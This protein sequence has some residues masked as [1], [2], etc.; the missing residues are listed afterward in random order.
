[1][2]RNSFLLFYIIIMGLSLA[3]CTNSDDD[4][5]T[6]NSSPGIGSIYV[7]SNPTAAQI[8]VDTT[9][10]GKITPDSVTNLSVGIHKV[11]IKMAGFLNDTAIVNIQE[12]VQ[13]P[14]SLTLKGDQSITEFGPIQIWETTVTDSTQPSGIV[15]KLGKASSII[16]GN[17][18]FVDIYFSS[19]GYVVATASDKNGRNTSFFVGLSD[20]LSDGMIS[21][22][23]IPS[24]VSQVSEMVNNYFF[25]F[26]FDSHYSKMVIIDKGGV[27]GS[28]SN[29]AWVKL[30]WLYNNKPN[31]PRF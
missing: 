31:D 16:T 26:D 25:L 7:V 27:Q 30:K 28:P 5:L 15:L 21:P 8:W 4:P 17:H 14:L 13:T 20:S 3:S 6:T 2:N 9:N 23:Y 18:A 19:N 22:L 10:T 24:W 29:P 12:G 11:I 1:M